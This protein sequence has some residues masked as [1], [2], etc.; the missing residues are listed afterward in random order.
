VGQST[1]LEKWKRPTVE[2]RLYGGTQ[3]LSFEV[4]G[5]NKIRRIKNGKI[6]L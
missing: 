6:L 2:S 3:D 1:K 4:G 5:K